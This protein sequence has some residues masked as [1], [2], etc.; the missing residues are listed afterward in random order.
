[1]SPTPKALQVRASISKAKLKPKRYVTGLV[2]LSDVFG[3]LKMAVTCVCTVVGSDRYCP[4]QAVMI[5]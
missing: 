1:M 4:V 5:L 2:W 3:S